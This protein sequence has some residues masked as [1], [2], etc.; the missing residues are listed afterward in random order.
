MLGK[1]KKIEEVPSEYEKYDFDRL[2]DNNIEIVA[3]MV[4]EKK[5]REELNINLQ[6]LA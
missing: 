3:K 1:V 6:C 4:K 2:L 5:A